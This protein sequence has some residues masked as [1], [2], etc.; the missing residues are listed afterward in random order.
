MYADLLPS[1]FLTKMLVTVDGCWEWEGRV[2][3][4]GYAMYDVPG[5][6][7]KAHRYTYELLVGPIPEGL[8]LDHLCRVRACVNPAHLE[9]V[10]HQE[11]MRR[12][13]HALKTH[14]PHGHTYTGENLRVRSHDNGRSCRTCDR[15]SVK[16]SRVAYN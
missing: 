11:N 6:A 5:R 14:C 10:T 15:A 2:N 3:E 9:P 12:G 16:R 4:K 1:R 8:E 13:A 7:V